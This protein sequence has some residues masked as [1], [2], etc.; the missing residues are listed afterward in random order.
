MIHYNIPIKLIVYC[1]NGYMGI[2][3]TQRKFFDSRLTGC[4]AETGIDFPDLKKLSDAFGIPY[5]RIDENEEIDKVLPDFLNQ[6]GYGICE[7]KE[8]SSQGPAF[9]TTSQ[10]L[11]SGEIVS[12]PLDR[13]E[14]ALSEEEYKKYRYFN[15]E[16]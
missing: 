6:P 4:T 1:N 10:K 9:K 3:R 11:D 7:L 12:A 13:L 2:V 14:P 8:D 15:K 16:N 5:T